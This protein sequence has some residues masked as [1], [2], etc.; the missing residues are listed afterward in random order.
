MA[1]RTTPKMAQ[2]KEAQRAHLLETAVG[3][4]G[5]HGYH[6]ATV[7]MIVK[8]SG[9]STGS[10]YF[11]FRNKEDVFAAALEEFGK[12][13]AQALNEAMAKAGAE[14]RLAM[15]AAVERLISFMAE[16]PDEARILVVE[17]SGLGP[18][19]QQI[20]RK[21]VDGHARAVEKGLQL[22]RPALTPI[23]AETIARCWVGSVYETVF[24]WLELPAA[25]RPAVEKVAR[26][27]ADFNLRGAGVL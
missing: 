7:P 14:P 6:A 19:L 17:T 25:K 23:A 11:Y 12:K 8:A 13:I 18:R 20:R 24:H 16:N 26:T 9:G 22:L 21:I 15:R 27:V 1:Y 3:L 4:F 2:R 10:F 5:K